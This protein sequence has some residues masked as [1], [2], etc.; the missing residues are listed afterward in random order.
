MQSELGSIAVLV[1]G[2]GRSLL[3]LA[4]AIREG[5]LPCSIRLVLCNVEDAPQANVGN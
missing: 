4:G 2:T 3:N 1:S 5:K